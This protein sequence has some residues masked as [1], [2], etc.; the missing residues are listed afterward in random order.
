MIS[1]P[2]TAGEIRLAQT[3]FG[4]SIDYTTVKVSDSPYVFFQP[5]N[6]AMAP[7]G[8]LY[9][10]NCYRADYAQTD[11]Y[12]RSLFIHEMTHVWQF[13]NGVLNPVAEA[14]K[15]YMKH[16]FNY[17]AAYD[18]T[19]DAKKDLTDYEME[20]QASIVEKYFLEK[21]EGVRASPYHQADQRVKLYEKVLK[22]FLTNPS[23]AKRSKLQ[24]FLFRQKP[25]QA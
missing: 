16:K 4:N 19:L 1:R 25:P 10:H 3:V 12:T 24:A 18:F 21:R 11:S 13:Q 17:A 8:N 22:N 6:A 15:L 7:N 14:V 20:Q 2:L 23:Y 9:M 5:A